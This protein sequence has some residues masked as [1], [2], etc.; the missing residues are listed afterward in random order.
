MWQASDRPATL[1]GPVFLFVLWDDGGGDG[2]IAANG[3][4]Q[5]GGMTIYCLREGQGKSLIINSWSFFIA[6]R[7]QP[8][9]G[10][11]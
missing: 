3:P 4:K 7:V 9:N 6:G 2:D 11:N 8:E 1:P 5:T 10:A